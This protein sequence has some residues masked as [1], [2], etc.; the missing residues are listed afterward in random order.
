[1]VSVTGGDG[2]ATEGG[3][4]AQVAELIAVQSATAKAKGAEEPV[5]MYIHTETLT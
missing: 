1:M 5:Y 4:R 3:G 2:I